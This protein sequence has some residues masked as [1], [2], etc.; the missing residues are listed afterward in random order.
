MD[1]FK[2]L[3]DLTVAKGVTGNERAAAKVVEGYFKAATPD[4]FYTTAGNLCARIG[5]G[6]P[7]VL[8]MSHMDEVGMMV[9][10]IEDNGMLRIRSVAGVD[11]RVLPGSPVMV[12][13]HDTQP[14]PG[15]VGAIP[16]HLLD[17]DEKEAY[18]IYDMVCDVGMSAERVRELIAVG[19]N[20]TFAPLP[21]V[22]LKN[23]R[24]AGKTFDD[25]AL[26]VAMLEAMDIL[27]RRKLDCTAVFCASVQEERGGIG[28][29]TGT[30]AVDPDIGIAAD[31]CH[32]P[33]PG[34]K[35]IETAP[36][37]NVCF[38]RGSN[39]HPG[40]VDRLCAV[41]KEQNIPYSVDVEMGHTGTD[42]WEMQLER[43]G[44]PCGLISLPLRYM[45]TSVECIDMNTLKNCA[46]VMAGF[47]ESISADWEDMLCWND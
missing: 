17:G 5:S 47:V 15:V 11:P 16:P 12:Y 19:D 41:A 27:A 30:H 46:K 21:P 6:K 10:Y 42:A 8:F 4:V 39:L 13:G 7:V 34:T 35:D 36:M 40:V 28:A 9:T 2:A 14:I 45:H 38:T 43:G 25:R 24:V 18:K 1:M 44:V 26:V 33:T 22:K 29:I 20:V 32:A 23:D 31:V 3:S 37:D